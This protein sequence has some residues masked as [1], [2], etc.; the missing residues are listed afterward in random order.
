[1]WDS[2]APPPANTQY[3]NAAYESLRQSA[4]NKSRDQAA[5]ERDLSRTID[6]KINQFNQLEAT[7]NNAI[8]S[9][10]QTLSNNQDDSD[11]QISKLYTQIQ[12][13]ERR[14][15]AMEHGSSMRPPSQSN[16]SSGSKYATTGYSTA[17]IRSRPQMHSSP[18]RTPMHV[19]HSA[20]PPTRTKVTPIDF[21]DVRGAEGE[22]LLSL[23]RDIVSNPGEYLYWHGYLAQAG[24]PALRF[25]AGEL[26]VDRRDL[27]PL[28]T[29]ND[30]MLDMDD[31]FPPTGGG[32]QL[33]QPNVS[34]EILRPQYT[35]HVR[36]LSTEQILD[37]L[38]KDAQ[39]KNDLPVRFQ[40]PAQ[41]SP[42][43][44]TTPNSRKQKLFAE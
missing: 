4:A 25:S 17:P 8:Q 12:D 41:L 11:E 23:L 14:L 32:I 37:L 13:Q 43:Q 35:G 24:P 21:S 36:E 3:L 22:Y 33:I 30:N 15:S 19:G 39:G 34:Q 26:N 7:R 44:L 27:I 9:G 38:D 6:Y 10:M 40:P 1:M 20:P 2:R 28:A 29:P 5:A 42:T 16:Y 18:S 31:L